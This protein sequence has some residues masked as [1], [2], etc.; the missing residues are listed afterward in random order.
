MGV[1]MPI[2]YEELLDEIG[3]GR[4]YGDRHVSWFCTLR[5]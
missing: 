1:T 3:G 2:N 4:C 5:I